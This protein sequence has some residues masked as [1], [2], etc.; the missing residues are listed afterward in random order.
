MLFLGA[1]IHDDL[2]AEIDEYLENNNL[3][4]TITI[5]PWGDSY[6]SRKFLEET[7]IFVMTSL[8]EG[9]P[10]SL[11]EAMS[12]GIPCV[13]SKVDGNTDVIN[14]NENGFSCLDAEEFVSKLEL[15]INDNMLRK[16]IGINGYRYVAEKHSIQKNIHHIEKLYEEMTASGEVYQNFQSENAPTLSVYH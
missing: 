9:L 16:A 15:L 8:F 14:N 1:G 7:D 11:L 10:F 3:K 2:S 4:N 6:T 12:L 5:E 13:V